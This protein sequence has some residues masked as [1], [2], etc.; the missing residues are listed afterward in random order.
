MN[1]YSWSDNRECFIADAVLQKGKEMEAS[2]SVE[3]DGVLYTADLDKLDKLSK[4]MATRGLAEEQIKVDIAKHVDECLQQV[5]ENVQATYDKAS[6]TVTVEIG[7][8]AKDDEP[9]LA[10]FAIK[11][12]AKKNLK[13][14]PIVRKARIS[15]GVKGAVQM[16]LF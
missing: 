13:T 16:S 8:T 2:L 4:E 15:K 9:A 12:S 5:I 3:R 14:V 7:C 11:T 10:V 1:T 6:F